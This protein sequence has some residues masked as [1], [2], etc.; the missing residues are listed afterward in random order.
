MENILKD[1]YLIIF[2]CRFTELLE[3]GYASWIATPILRV[4]KGKQIL[5]FYT[6]AQY[7]EWK[8]NTPNYATWG[9]P[10]YFKGLGTSTKTDIKSDSL[11]P[12]YV[13]C[14]YDDRAKDYMELAFNDKLAD[15]RKKWIANYKEYIYQDVPQEVEV[16]SFINYDLIRYSIY[17]IQRSVPAWDGLKP[18]QR[19][20]LWASYKKWEW[21][22]NRN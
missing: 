11:D 10:K 8:R 1:Y 15:E 19:K 3:R 22:K 17:D 14:I 6:P 18:S 12:K 7:E 4:A 21:D 16:S 2:H 13:S 9:K 20:I 5:K